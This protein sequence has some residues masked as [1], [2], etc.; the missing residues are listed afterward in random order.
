MR[1]H[2]DLVTTLADKRGQDFLYIADQPQLP[3]GMAGYFAAVVPVGRLHYAPYP[4]YALDYPVYQLQGF[5]G[6]QP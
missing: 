3:E 4:G 5:R 1:H 2:Y 6:V